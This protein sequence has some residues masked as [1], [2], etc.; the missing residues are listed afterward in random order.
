MCFD[1][2]KSFCSFSLPHP[3]LTMT[4]QTLRFTSFKELAAFIKGLSIGYL[5][6]TNTLTVTAS[7][8]ESHVRHALECFDAELIDTNEKAYSYDPI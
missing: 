6:N 4:K 2:L 1:L 7:F 8:L 5:I 3:P